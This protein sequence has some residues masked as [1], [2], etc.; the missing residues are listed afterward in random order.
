MTNTSTKF[1]EATLHARKLHG[2]IKAIQYVRLNIL[3][4]NINE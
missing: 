4:Y 2:I 3:L 1:L